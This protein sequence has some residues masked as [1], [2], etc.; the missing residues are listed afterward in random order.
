TTNADR[1]P[2][3]EG[4]VC[5]LHQA[6]LKIGA[7]IDLME[8]TWST[9]TAAPPGSPAFMPVAERAT[10]GLIIVN[11]NGKRYVNESVP[12]HEFVDEM[13]KNNSEEASTVPSWM[14]LDQ[15]A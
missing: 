14:I 6:R 15:R 8:K 7:K 9:P 10:P 3:K 2:A 1:V 4:Q 13:Y 5:D 12:Y 11:N